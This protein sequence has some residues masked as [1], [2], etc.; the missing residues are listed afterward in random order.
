MAVGLVLVV[1]LVVLVPSGYK[2]RGRR[3]GCGD[4]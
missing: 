3:C 2:Y 1:I 4:I